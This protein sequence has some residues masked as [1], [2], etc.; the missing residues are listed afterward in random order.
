[1]FYLV[2]VINII[3]MYNSILQYITEHHFAVL[4]YHDEDEGTGSL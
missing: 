2:P 4:R 1:V 3:C